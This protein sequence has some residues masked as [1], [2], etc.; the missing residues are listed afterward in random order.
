MTRPL[1][2]GRC[3]NQVQKPCGGGRK[4]RR[5]RRV[6][7]ETRVR[8]RITERKP[9]IR[10]TPLEKTPLFQQP[11]TRIGDHILFTK[12][13]THAEFEEF[14]RVFLQRPKAI[15][16]CGGLAA[17]LKQKGITHV[18]I[19]RVRYAPVREEETVVCRE[20]GAGQDMP[21]A[22]DVADRRNAQY[23][24]EHVW[25]KPEQSRWLINRI[26]NSSAKVPELLAEGVELAI[27]RAEAGLTRE[28]PIEVFIGN[29]RLACH[30]LAQQQGHAEAETGELQRAWLALEAELRALQKSCLRQCSR[31]FC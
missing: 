25:Q 17:L 2:V 7:T 15:N 22:P 12:E 8:A 18:E 5:G 27:S 21:K 28:K 14:F 3:R 1:R 24:V 13:L 30:N 10:T 29:I 9:V 26:K 6:W 11:A 16:A 20:A 23:M 19:Q 31:R 4:C